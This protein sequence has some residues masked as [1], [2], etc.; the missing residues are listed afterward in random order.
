MT[1]WMGEL[2]HAIRALGRNPR[3]SAIVVLTLALGLG[4]NTTIFSLV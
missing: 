1:R 2:T 3:L 4:A